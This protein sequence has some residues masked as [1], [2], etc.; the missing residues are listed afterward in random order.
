MLQNFTRPGGLDLDQISS[1]FNGFCYGETGSCVTNGVCQQVCS[2]VCTLPQL[3]LGFIHL[4][5]KRSMV[6]EVHKTAFGWNVL[7]GGNDEA[8]RVLVDVFKKYLDCFVL[9]LVGKF[10]WLAVRACIC[11]K[12]EELKW[13]FVENHMSQQYFEIPEQS[14]GAQPDVTG[15]KPGKA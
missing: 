6:T 15:C 8:W 1:G 5:H 10:G 4:R 12:T 14:L 11:V 13:A 3:Y 7:S 2:D 9:R